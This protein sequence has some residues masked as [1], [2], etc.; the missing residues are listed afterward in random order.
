MTNEFQDIRDL[1]SDPKNA[2][3]HNPKNIGT[4]VDSLHEVGVG[5]SIVV[6]EAGVVL[7]GNGVLEACGE[8]GIHRVQVV[9]AD[10]ETIIAVR[11]TGLTPEQKIRLALFDNRASDFSADEYDLEILSALAPT[12]ALK[13][14]WSPVEIECLMDMPPAVEWKEFTGEES[15]ELDT[16]FSQE[17]ENTAKEK[18]SRVCTCPQCG[19][20]WSD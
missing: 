6:D 2:R 19:Y 20:Q 18:S 3:R 8:A 10:G 13:G 14:L 9:D 12:G 7:A 16:A 15:E 11:R 4:I 5:R 1:K 17:M